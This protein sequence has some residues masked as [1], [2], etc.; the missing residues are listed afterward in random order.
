MMRHPYIF[1]PRGVVQGAIAALVLGLL[2]ICSL[3]ARASMPVQ[4]QVTGS[5][6]A[7]D[8]TTAVTINGTTY[9]IA[10]DS[11]AAR[12]IQSVSVGDTIGL[13]LSGPAGEATSQVVYILSGSSGASSKA[14]Q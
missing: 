10:P 1:K 13:V 4:A 5:V 2:G 8:G 12:S 11:L 14:S 3:P 7:V 9:L 6:S